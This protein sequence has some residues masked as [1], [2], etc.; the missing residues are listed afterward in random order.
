MKIKSFFIVSILAFI[1][2]SCNFPGLSNTSRPTS[3]PDTTIGKEGLNLLVS[4]NGDVQLKR[5]GWNNFSPTSLGT[6]LYSGDQIKPATDASAVILCEGL[7]K[8]VVPAGAPAGLSNGC[9]PT[10]KP[11]LVRGSSHIGGTRGGSDPLIPYI[12]SP[13]K[14]QV[15]TARPVL[16]WNA[17][18][19]AKSYS[20]SISTSQVI[21]SAT[22][23]Q[24]SL[25]YPGTPALKPGTTYLLEVKADNGSQSR[26]EGVAGLGFS[27]MTSANNAQVIK[28]INAISALKLTDEAKALALAQLYQGYNLEAEAIEV[29]LP[30]AEE[31]TQVAAVYRLL[32]ELYLKSG[33]NLLAE[34]NY[35][36]A[37]DLSRS[38]ND[39]EGQ[40]LS[41]V[42][43]GEAEA[44][45][46]KKDAAIQQLTQALENF[47][48]LGDQT[49]IDELNLRLEQL[50]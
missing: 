3:P 4:V 36:Q 27:L 40:A 32:A 33:L 23:D 6:L 48:Q 46:G 35:Q 24:S 28:S 45:L 25:V 7:S 49:W 20:V 18:P 31:Q 47:T 21:W 11:V 5:S 2:S 42:G 39:I 15:I 9:P 30:L 16:R 10:G 17:V 44:A 34:S 29:L 26:D 1:I 37:D 19:G 41:Q 12:I 14:T 38:T 13:R 22:T 8:W 43:M 50:R